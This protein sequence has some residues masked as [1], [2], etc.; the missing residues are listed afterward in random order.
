MKNIKTIIHKND[1]ILK[2]LNTA[3]K[4]ETDGPL[5]TQENPYLIHEFCVQ[6][7]SR[8]GSN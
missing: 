3:N 2:V 6:N 5:H 4:R 1:Y 7:Q 8:L